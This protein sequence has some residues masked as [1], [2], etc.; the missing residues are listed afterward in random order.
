MIRFTIPRQDYN[1]VTVG[2]TNISPSELDEESF[3]VDPQGTLTI[4]LGN[5]L[6]A[7]PKTTLAIQ[8]AVEIDGKIHVLMPTSWGD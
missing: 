1:I 8:I 2:S 3:S 4:P 7:E 6:V 5:M